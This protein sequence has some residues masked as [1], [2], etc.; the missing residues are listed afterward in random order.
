MA[1]GT[2]VSLP[3][4]GALTRAFGWPWAFYAPGAAALVWGL[5][6]AGL[7]YDSPASHPRI[8]PAEMSLF[9]VL[10]AAKSRVS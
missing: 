9:P 3:A 4:S 2:V 1:W 8:H 5:V 7:V 10:P 6:G